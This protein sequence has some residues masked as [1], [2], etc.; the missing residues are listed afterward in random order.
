MDGEDR[1][2]RP[3][4]NAAEELAACLRWIRALRGFE[5]Y[6]SENSIDEM[7][8]CAADSTIIVVNITDIRSDAMVVT[9]TGVKLLHL[10]KIIA[11][12][13]QNW[14]R[15][16]WLGGGRSKRGTKNREY[17]EYLL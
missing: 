17:R 2:R 16:D 5:R 11:S 10:P 7:L 1:S 14:L 12:K 8:S 9:P 3:S 6:R 4:A 13:A 15:K